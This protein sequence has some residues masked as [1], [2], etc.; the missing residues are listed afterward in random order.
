[1]GAC[2]QRGPN[3]VALR[4][5]LHGF[6]GCGAFHRNGPTGGAANGIPRKTRTPGDAAAAP[7]T[8][9]LSVFTRS[10]ASALAAHRVISSPASEAK[11]TTL[12]PAL[13]QPPGSGGYDSLTLF[14]CLLGSCD[15]SSNRPG[16][17]GMVHRS[18]DWRHFDCQPASD[19]MAFGMERMRS[20]NQRLPQANCYG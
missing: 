10:S 14:I 1:M 9:P 19:R 5:P 17:C 6:T 8:T 3:S 13:I 20:G 11:H 4:T 12:F 16:S 18:D 15:S 7:S 2:T